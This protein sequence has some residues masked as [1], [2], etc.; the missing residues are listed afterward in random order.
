[1]SSWWW[2]LPLVRFNWYYSLL[3][4]FDFFLSFFFYYDS[5]STRV[6]TVGFAIT[7]SLLRTGSLWCRSLWS[8]KGE[9]EHQE[10]NVGRHQGL[11]QLYELSK[12]WLKKITVK[13]S[14]LFY[15]WKI[16]PSAFEMCTS[17]LA[18]CMN[19]KELDTCLSIWQEFWKA[20]P[21]ENAKQNY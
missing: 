2:N 3:F 9:Q 21:L 19:T 5:V 4:K 10:K 15:S 18:N 17:Y 14:G 8:S 7:F 11:W 16:S 20:L 1:M 6:A 13:C 12:L